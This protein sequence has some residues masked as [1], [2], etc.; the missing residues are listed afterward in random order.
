MPRW[1]KKG[2]PKRKGW[3]KT[4]RTRQKV[5]QIIFP[6][7]KSTFPDSLAVDLFYTTEFYTQTGTNNP[8]GS[9]SYFNI[10]GGHAGDPDG[11]SGGGPT[12]QDYTHTVATNGMGGTLSDQYGTSINPSFYAVLYAAYNEMFVSSCTIEVDVWCSS[13]SD[14][15]DLFVVPLATISQNTTSLQELS[16]ARFTKTKRIGYYNYGDSHGTN[17]IKH[18]MSFRKMVGQEASDK[19]LMTQSEYTSSASGANAYNWIWQI[20]YQPRSSLIL[21]GYQTWRISCKYHCIYF[22]PQRFGT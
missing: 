16:E 2:S 15:G 21:T 8:N 9:M 3:K 20:A 4:G 19:T 18:H 6:V 17:T 5:H 7:G 13:P 1:V 10:N 12:F 22:N 11:N 14:S